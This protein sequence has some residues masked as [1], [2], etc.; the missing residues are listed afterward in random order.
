LSTKLDGELPNIDPDAQVIYRDYKQEY[1]R[2]SRGFI[3]SAGEVN[4]DVTTLQNSQSFTSY[5]IEYSDE[6]TFNE[7]PHA[8]DTGVYTSRVNSKR[9]FIRYTKGDNL[10]RFSTANF[11][12]PKGKCYAFFILALD[13]IKSYLRELD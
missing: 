10:L 12:Y 13:H 5:R 6:I 1:T 8:I 7:C 11:I 3:R 4:Y 2:Y 9:V